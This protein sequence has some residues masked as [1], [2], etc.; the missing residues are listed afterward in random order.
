MIGAEFTTICFELQYVRFNL[1]KLLTFSPVI[2]GISA[3]LNAI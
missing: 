3:I 2:A 1:S